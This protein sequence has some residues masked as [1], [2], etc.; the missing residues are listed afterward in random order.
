M[1][2]SLI[3]SDSQSNLVDQTNEGALNLRDPLVHCELLKSYYENQTL[4]K[5]DWEI[6]EN[7]T[8]K[9]IDSAS[10]NEDES[11]NIKWSINQ[12]K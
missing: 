8:K 3:I 6:L 11:R 4:N 1:S 5:S 10:K 7:M 12:T 2:E 9:Y